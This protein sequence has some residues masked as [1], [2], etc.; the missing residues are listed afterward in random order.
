MGNFI[1]KI[2]QNIPAIQREITLNGKNLIIVGNNG[3]GKTKFLH[4]LNDYLSKV[5]NKD[6]MVTL[7][8][9]EEYKKEQENQLKHYEN[10]NSRYHTVKQNIGYYDVR[11]KERLCFDVIFEKPDLLFGDI[12]D[13]RVITRF[14][15]AHRRYLSNGQNLLTSVDTLFNDF[16]AVSPQQ[17]VTCDY[18][19][20]YLVSMSNYALIEK[21]AE[22]IDEYERVI[23][24]IS[25]IEN[26]LK[27][28]FEDETLSIHYNRKKL[29]I[30]IL[31]EG[32]EPSG[33]DNLPSGFASVLAIYAELIMLA[34]LSE[35]T[36]D[37][38][39]G[40]VLV[41]EIDAHLHVTVQKKVFNFF[42]ESF[43][44]VQFIIT[45][46]SPFVVQ[47]VSDAVIFNLNTG[48]QMENLS[49]Y[50][51]TSIIKGLLGESGNSSELEDLLSE[52][53]KMSKDNDFGSRFIEL[54]A[55][56]EQNFSV[57]DARAKA[58]FMGA[59]AKMVD[60]EEAQDNV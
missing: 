50:S 29:R 45:T 43:P 12:K 17:L 34:E 16:K 9:L 22:S 25:K 15:P 7:K 44:N 3:A 14:F 42:S 10:V 38:I 32:K 30:E 54:S 39:R 4:A 23:K 41:D 31:Q 58:V 8:Q 1:N 51:Y 33:F 13:N 19:E 21:G 20:R 55:L 11:I 26:D 48:E 40:I 6:Y 28:L 53:D 36:K 57:L 46:H 60:W 27:V 2:M 47:S 59:K 18:F 24:V 52:I 35:G 56:L 49:V 5:F 37:D